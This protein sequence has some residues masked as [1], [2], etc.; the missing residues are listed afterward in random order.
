M[1]DRLDGESPTLSFLFQAGSHAFL[2]GGQF[3]S[4]EALIETVHPP[5][6]SKNSDNRDPTATE[7]KSPSGTVVRLL[8]SQEADAVALE[9]IYNYNV[10]LG[11]C[12]SQVRSEPV[13]S[14]GDYLCTADRHLSGAQIRGQHAMSLHI[15]AIAI[16]AAFL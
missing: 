4:I 16:R 11:R 15:L 7:E 8:V 13:T 14:T 10:R 2:V 1:R 12:D 3:S 5:A 9:S 6:Y